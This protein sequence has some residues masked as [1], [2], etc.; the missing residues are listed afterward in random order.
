MVCLPWIIIHVLLALYCPRSKP[1]SSRSTIILWFSWNG[2]LHL[3]VA[4]S[5]QKTK[6]I[7]NAI[8]KISKQTILRQLFLWLGWGNFTLVKFTARMFAKVTVALAPWAI[9]HNYYSIIT[10]DRPCPAGGVLGGFLQ[11]NFAICKYYFPVDL[12]LKPLNTFKKNT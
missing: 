10:Q 8:K 2:G 6:P 5:L 11:Q 9:D 4:S 7:R 3:N 12:S 1:R